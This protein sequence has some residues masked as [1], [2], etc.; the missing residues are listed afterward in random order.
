MSSREE[1]IYIAGPMTG[2]R[3]YNVHAFERAQR[4]WRI[5]GY[6]V[7][8]P[9]DTNSVVWQ[10]EYE[11]DFDPF[12]DVC[13]YGDPLLR[14]MWKENIN[15]L[16]D[17]DLLVFLDGWE[18]SKGALIERAI[19]EIFNIPCVDQLGR[20]LNGQHDTLLTKHALKHAST[21]GTG[22]DENSVLEG[23]WSDYDRR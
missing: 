6:E 10:R 21:P 1:Q 7:I 14:E 20:P 17:A 13:E 9:F 23:A 22:T 19:A 5:K 11:R 12:R 18:K 2:H 4:K 16:L 3:Y 8:T 15:A